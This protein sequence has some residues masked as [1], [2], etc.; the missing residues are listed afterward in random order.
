[1]T[2]SPLMLRPC[3]LDRLMPMHLALDGSGRVTSAG[4]TF[5]RLAGVDPAGRAVFDLLRLR[6]PEGVADV[7]GLRSVVGQKLHLTLLHANLRLAGIAVPARGGAGNGLLLNLSPGPGVV[8]AVR[9]FSLSNGDFAPTDLANELLFLAEANAAIA[10]EAA[11]L[12][13]RLQNAHS[14]AEE[15]S[16]TDAL[17]GLRN[18]RGLDQ[19]MDTLARGGGRFAMLAVDLDRF[20]AVNDAMGHAVGDTVLRAATEAMVRAAR[21]ADLVA[22]I[23]GDEFAILLYGAIPRDRLGRIADD[24]IAAIERPIPVEGGLARISASVGI[25]ISDDHAIGD[26]ASVTAAADAALYASKQAGRGCWTLMG[27]STAPEA[28]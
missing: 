12:T 26:V 9:R 5:A 23:G 6:R 27:G 17:T 21:A 24:L 10:A 18:R 3:A 16:F 20:K 13:A 15:R 25:A 1:M 2:G 28:S 22:R 14:D 4:R 8:A 19:A 11:A 7:D